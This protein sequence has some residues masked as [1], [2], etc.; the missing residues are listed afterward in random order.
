METVEFP[1]SFME[2]VIHLSV[3]KPPF[4]LLP[5]PGTPF[6]WFYDKT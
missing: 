2:K 5:L 1:K 3:K 6:F 4:G